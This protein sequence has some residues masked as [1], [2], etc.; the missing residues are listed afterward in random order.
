MTAP[1]QGPA[2]WLYRIVP[3]RPGMPADPTPQEASLVSAH[4]DYLVGLAERG[5]LILAGRTLDD[6]TFGIVVFEAADEAAAREVAAADP[7]VAAGAFAM[8]LHPYRVAVARDG[9]TRPSSG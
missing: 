4:F 8:T 2:Q 1:A 3:S 5:V 9:L 6:E 7:A